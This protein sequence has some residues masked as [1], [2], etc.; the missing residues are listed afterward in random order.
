MP[1]DD[2]HPKFVVARRAGGPVL[3]NDYVVGAAGID[4]E[5]VDVSVAVG[6]G[7]V[8]GRQSAVTGVTQFDV[9][10]GVAG[11]RVHAYREDVVG[12]RAEAPVVGIAPVRAVGGRIDRPAAAGDPQAASRRILHQRQRDSAADLVV[13]VPFSAVRRIVLGWIRGVRAQRRGL[14]RELCLNTFLCRT[15]SIVRCRIRESAARRTLGG[16]LPGARI[17]HIRIV[18]ASDHL[19]GAG[20]QPVVR[21]N[22][23]CGNILEQIGTLAG[24]RSRFPALFVKQYL[25]NRLRI[26]T[27]KFH[28]GNGRILRSPERSRRGSRFSGVVLAASHRCRHAFPWRSHS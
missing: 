15:R 2:V 7:A 14:R 17:R 28:R 16:V 5:P 13:R 19:G 21:E 25:F 1:R 24:H 3:A 12:E 27:S 10:V 22:L 26:L 23:L 4:R 8:V 18:A 11:G 20:G 6:P 9:R